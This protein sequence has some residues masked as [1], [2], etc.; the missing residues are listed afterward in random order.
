MLPAPMMAILKLAMAVLFLLR[1]RPT[2]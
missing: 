2:R 1:L